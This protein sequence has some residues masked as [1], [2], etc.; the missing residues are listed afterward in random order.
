[1]KKRILR[2]EIEHF[3]IL[4]T[5]LLFLFLSG[6]VIHTKADLAAS[7]A[8]LAFLALNIYLLFN[9]SSGKYLIK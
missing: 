8:G 1:M 4:A 2:P 7:L 9:Y 3:L 6:V 5:I